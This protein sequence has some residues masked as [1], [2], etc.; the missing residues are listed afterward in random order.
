MDATRRGE[1]S[2][3]VRSKYYV[4]IKSPQTYDAKPITG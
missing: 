4:N 1:V 3:G 2:G